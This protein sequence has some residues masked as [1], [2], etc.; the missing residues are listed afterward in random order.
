M[1]WLLIVLVVVAVIALVRTSGGR[2]IGVRRRH[3]ATAEEMASVKRA[4][5]EDVT[6][7][8][9]QLQRLDLDL[10]GRELDE[11]T[12]ADYQRALDDYEAAK[13]SVAAVSEPDEIR[14]V[15]EILEDGR[16]AVA[17]VQ[18]RVAGEPLPVRRAPGF[19]NPQHGPS[20]RD[21]SWTPSGGT[22]REV[23]ACEL[24]AQRV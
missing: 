14:H 20:A 23:P 5:D 11:T 21:V 15:T 16:Y 19:F 4:A 22:A 7:F 12:R 1:E 6:Q 17:C 2:Q 18:A 13:E 24:D 10:A 8:G 9:E 3:Q